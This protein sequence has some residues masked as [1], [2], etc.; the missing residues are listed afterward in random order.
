[1]MGLAWD[2]PSVEPED[3]RGKIVLAINFSG[4]YTTAKEEL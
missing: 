3:G 1:M 2:M 4:G